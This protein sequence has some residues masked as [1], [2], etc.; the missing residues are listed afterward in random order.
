MARLIQT[1]NTSD[2]SSPSP[3]PSGIVLIGNSNILLI[4]DSEV[5]ENPVFQGDNLYEVN[6]NGDLLNTGN[7]LEISSEPTGLAYNPNNGNLFISDDTDNSRRIYQVDGGNDGIFGTSDDIEV[8]N[9]RTIP[10]GSNDAEDVAYS[11]SS[12]N[13]FVSDGSSS[14]IY[15]VTTNGNLISSF[16][17]TNFGLSDPEGIGF[18]TQSGNLFIVG[19]P[20]TTVF[21]V[22]SNGTLVQTIDISIVNPIQPAGIEIASSS[23]GSGRSIY[24][25]D[26]GVDERDDPNEND[27]RLYEFSLEGNDNPDNPGGGGDEVFY[28]TTRDSANLNGNIFDDEDV[29]VYDPTTQTWS[30]YLDGSDLGLAANDIDGV[31][32][33]NDGSVLF[34]LNQD[35]NIDGLGNVDDADILRFNPT[36]TGDNTTGSLELYL[37]GSD[38]GLDSNPEDIDGISIASNGDILISTNGSYNI[39]GLSGEDKDILA[40]A[41][42]S[43]GS[44]TTGSFSLYVDGSD[45]SL[46]DN[47][48]D[49]KGLSVLDSGELVLSTLGNFQVEGLSGS[50]SDLFSFNPNSLGN[51]TSGS[52]SLFSSGADNGLGNQVVADISVV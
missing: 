51:N 11:T 33:N 17:T 35:S 45:I 32:V 41:S 14:T 19:E 9:F 18:D 21:E 10:F 46:S 38:V 42:S 2:F 36:S 22:A 29:I 3:D 16:S 52:F 8:S 23:D 48:E 4:S 50:G 1:V 37:D 27:G 26:R 49:V 20:T 43:L 5:N 15:E 31:H 28:A 25:V 39:N 13:L 47:S 34:S 30:Q 12:G 44:N 40:F 6:L 7:V 24:I